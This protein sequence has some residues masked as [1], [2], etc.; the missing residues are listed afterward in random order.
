MKIENE[1]TNVVYKRYQEYCLAN[2][3]QPMSNIEFSKQVNRILG[4]KI[5]DKKIN[6]KKYRIFVSN[7]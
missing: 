7:Y 3:L 4:L 1:P 2:S 6:G 5:I